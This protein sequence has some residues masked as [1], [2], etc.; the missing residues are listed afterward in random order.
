MTWITIY[1]MDVK[2]PRH[3]L[4]AETT[5]NASVPIP[6]QNCLTNTTFDLVH[7]GVTGEDSGAPAVPW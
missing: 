2:Y 3:R 7:T 1:V 4:G 6:L 5:V